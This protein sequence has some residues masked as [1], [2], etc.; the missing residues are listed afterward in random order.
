VYL[1]LGSCIILH[2][3][4]L[5]DNAG[6]PAEEEVA[7]VIAAEGP[8][9]DPL[10]GADEAH[11]QLRPRNGL[12]SRFQDNSGVRARLLSEISFE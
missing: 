6:A 12:A 8:E 3:I 7:A 5:G 11:S 2:N 9:E 1:W 10:D 4:L